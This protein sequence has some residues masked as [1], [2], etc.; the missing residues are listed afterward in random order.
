VPDPFLGLQP[1]QLRA[2]LGAPAFARKDGATE[3]W[4]YDIPSCRG[5]F[6]FTGTPAKVSQ[7]DT[8][9]EGPGNSGDPLCLKALRA[10]LPAKRS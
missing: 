7:V 6:F 2:L 3:M 5:F 9:P 10:S 1:T 4:R 8:L